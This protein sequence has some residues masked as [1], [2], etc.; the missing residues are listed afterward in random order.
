MKAA[1]DRLQALAVP[2]PTP[3]VSG[4]WFNIRFTPDLAGGEL[5]NIGVGYVDA[6]RQTVQARLIE[7]LEAFRTLFGD[8]LQDEIRF[9]LD[10][11]RSAVGQKLLNSPIGNVVFGERRFAAGESVQEVLAR[12]FSATVSFSEARN[13]FLIANNAAGSGDFPA[14]K[15]RYS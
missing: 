14:K 4:Q 11:V 13:C 9:S 6:D 8:A 1:L 2:V 7:N 15:T 5:F 3:K 12:L 10:V